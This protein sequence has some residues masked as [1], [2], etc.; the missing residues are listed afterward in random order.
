ENQKR[1]VDVKDSLALFRVQ[2][3]EELHRDSGEGS[4][5]NFTV[6]VAS[7][8][9]AGAL[10]LPE[11]AWHRLRGGTLGRIVRAGHRDDSFSARRRSLSTMAGPGVH[12]RRRSVR[13]Q[14]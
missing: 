6:S 3:F 7:S 10:E 2:R 13:S 4:A 11:P 12:H 1:P 8:L 5:I 9:V 14:P